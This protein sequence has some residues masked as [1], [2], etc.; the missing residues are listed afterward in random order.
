MS[1]F[2]FG[3]K[4]SE[5]VA[6]ALF[7]SG[8]IKEDPKDVRRIVIDLEVG[9]AARIYVEL[10][11]DNERLAAGLRAGLTLDHPEVPA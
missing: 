3:A 10:F 11:A 8:A 1:K 9:A 5:D 7:K 4:A 6:N 2:V